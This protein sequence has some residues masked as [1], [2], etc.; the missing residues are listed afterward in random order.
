MGRGRAI[1]RIGSLLRKA[2]SESTTSG[3]AQQAEECYAA[4][5]S[6]A[7]PKR[8]LSTG[9]SKSLRQMNQVASGASD[10]QFVVSRRL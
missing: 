8:Y 4:L 6:V 10:R 2:G 9:W 5:R 7:E 3:L 1:S